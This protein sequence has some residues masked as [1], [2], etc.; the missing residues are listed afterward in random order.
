MNYTL[1]TGATGYLG[2]AFARECAR[3]GENLYLTGRNGEKL[4]ALKIE[5]ASIGAEGD[6]IT[7][8][9][10]LADGQSRSKLFGDAQKYTFSRLIN[11]AGA[12]IQKAFALYDQQKLTFQIRAN[13]EGAVSMCAFCLSHRADKFRIINISSI[14]GEYAMPYFAI[15]SAAKGALTSFSIAIANEY[16][17][18]GVTVTAVLPGAIHTRPDVEEYIK[19]QGVW[20]RIAAKTPQ[21][22][23][24]KALSASDNG[25]RKI[26][27]GAANKIIYYASKVVPGVFKTWLIA[28][29]WRSTQK[30]AF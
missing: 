1:I 4:A 12:D 23:A 9:C 14:C 10:D 16:K 28:K 11:V 19:T 25:K 17:K 29:R 5:L 15:Y 20:G 13:F 30:D 18:S 7:F 3:R 22:V 24:V 2:R 27:P 26:V 6:I 21:Y 8:P